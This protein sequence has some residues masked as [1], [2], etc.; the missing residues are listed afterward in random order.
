VTTFEALG[1]LT[2]MRAECV[3]RADYYRKILKEK[4]DEEEKSFREEQLK[5][6]QREIQAIDKVGSLLTKR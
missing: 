2:D 6:Y 3:N 4:S 5:K 1:V